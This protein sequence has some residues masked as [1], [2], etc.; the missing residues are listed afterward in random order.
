MH[1][2]AIKLYG[3][4]YSI[5]HDNPP[6]ATS[7][8]PWPAN[9]SMTIWRVVG[10]GKWL[11]I[12]RWTVNCVRIKGDCFPLRVNPCCPLM[13]IRIHTNTYRDHHDIHIMKCNWYAQLATHAIPDMSF[14]VWSYCCCSSYIYIFLYLLLLLW[15][16]F[17]NMLS[18]FNS[19]LCL[20]NKISFCIQLLHTEWQ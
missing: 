4:N 14:W 2:T 9:L 1:T 19:M 5:S 15:N 10:S 3:L 6:R 17:L 16:F 18:Y 12:L 8:W 20:W 13:P 11:Y 7:A